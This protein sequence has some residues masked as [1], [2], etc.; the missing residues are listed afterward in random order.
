MNSLVLPAPATAAMPSA[1]RSA[2]RRSTDL[3]GIQYA[4]ALAAMMVVVF[5]LQPQCLRMGYAPPLWSGLAGGVDVFF[6][7]SGLIM[8]ITTCDRETAPLTF[9]GRRLARIVPLYWMATSVSVVLMLLAPSVLQTARFDLPHVIASYAFLAWRNP[10]TGTFEPV[11][12]PGWT[13]NYE[14]FFYLVFAVLLLVR[15]SRRLPLA[16][17]LF[18]ALAALGTLTGAARESW[19]GFYTSPLMLEFVAGMVL[20]ELHARSGWLDRLGQRG[21]ALAIAGG[22]ALLLAGPE[23]APTLP[24][25]VLFGVPAAAVVAG[26]LALDALGA[27][28]ENRLFLLLGNAS[29]SLYLVHPFVLSALSQ[30]WRKAHL[31]T[32]PGG[33]ALFALL[34]VLLCSLLAVLSYRLVELPLARVLRGRRR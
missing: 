15:R 31:D 32:L 24:R 4:R 17:A 10:G 9:L 11:V 7:I 2:A 25:F 30:F 20:G 28:R 19:L 5:H 13:L 34:A 3:I 29:Y 18:G 8:W 12:I 26:M 33:L 22:L 27:V 23:L 14:M 1:A 16:V 6:V 21:A